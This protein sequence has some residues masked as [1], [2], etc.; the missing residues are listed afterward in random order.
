MM[1]MSSIL[2]SNTL[3]GVTGFATSGK[4]T[5]Y[6]ICRNNLPNS[7]NTKRYAFADEL[8]AECDSFLL[9]NVGISAFTSDPYEKEIIKDQEDDER[10]IVDEAEYSEEAKTRLIPIRNILARHEL[11]VAIFYTKND[12]HIAS[13]NRSKFIIEK[14]PNTPSVPA[15]LHLIAHNYDKINAP[16]LAED[17][18]RVL[19]ASYP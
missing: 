5:L 15:A 12:A 4:D 9:E 6:T 1:K 17:A 11:Y 10:P 3:I 19:K 18:R 16:K 7:F 14:F 13:I 2:R 8:K